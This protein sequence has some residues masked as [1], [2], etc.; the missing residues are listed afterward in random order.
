MLTLIEFL[1]P[2]AKKTLTDKSIAVLYYESR[3]NKNQVLAGSEIRTKLVSCRIPNSKGANVTALLNQVGAYVDSPGLKDGERV[4]RLT[5]TGAAYVRQLLGLAADSPEL[6]QDIIALEALISRMRNAD[7]RDYLSEAATCLKVGALRAT[8]VFTW[9][10]TIRNIQFRC[11]KKG[12]LLTPALQRHDPRARPVNSIDDFAYIRDST[13]L[14]AC[15]DLGIFD[16]SQRETLEEA[17]K[18]RNRCGH[19]AKYAPREKK[20]SSFIEDLLSVVFT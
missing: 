14:L 7:E 10:A 12:K 3:Y 17:L 8:V 16:K 20:V 19:P 15:Q 18:L 6:V 5:D 4:W 13:V 2:L 1:Q 9:T 11:L